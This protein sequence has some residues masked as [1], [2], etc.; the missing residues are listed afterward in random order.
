M[1]E[2]RQFGFVPILA[3]PLALSY[4]M[5]RVDC[6]RC[7]VKVERVPWADGKHSQCNAFRHFLATWAKSLRWKETA[8]CLAVEWDTVR[9]SVQ[10][11]V[12]YHRGHKNMTLVDQIDAGK[13]QFIGVLKERTPQSLKDF[14]TVDL[15]AKRCA[16]IKV[17]CSD[18]WKPYLKFIA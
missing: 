4:R 18:M 14:F 12:A 6:P 13:K 17:V 10:W 16:E 9:R 7:G 2:P 5:Q 15:G 8:E 1:P 3:I 11:V